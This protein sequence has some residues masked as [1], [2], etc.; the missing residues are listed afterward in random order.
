MSD[1]LSQEG[2]GALQIKT[3]LYYAGHIL[4]AYEG[5]SFVDVFRVNGPL[6][7]RLE[8]EDF[9]SS[10]KLSVSQINYIVM[11]RLDWQDRQFDTEQRAQKQIPRK[12]VFAGKYQSAEMPSIVDAF[13]GD[14]VKR[15]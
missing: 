12:I 2:S 9:F 4:A 14:C 6:V 1:D 5:A 13:N 8:L 11:P 15:K 10:S 3:V 7:E